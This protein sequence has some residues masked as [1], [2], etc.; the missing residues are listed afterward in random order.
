MSQKEIRVGAPTNYELEI[1]S[2]LTDNVVLDTPDDFNLRRVGV[3]RLARAEFTNSGSLG[4]VING[5]VPLLG[6]KLWSSKLLKVKPDD[7][8]PRVD[9]TAQGILNI[10]LRDVNGELIDVL[11]ANDF[12]Y[13]NIGSFWCVVG[14]SGYLL[15]SRHSK[16]HNQYLD[17]N[18]KAAQEGQRPS[19]YD[20]SSFTRVL[21]ENLEGQRMFRVVAGAYANDNDI[22]VVNEDTRRLVESQTDQPFKHGT[23]RSDIFEEFGPLI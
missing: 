5:G 8:T 10:E 6:T 15:D 19:F 22:Y 4:R 1:M 2:R 18:L 9:W 17:V 20:R 11:G 16:S 13:V 21:E 23:I 3:L 14:E 12:R 7:Y